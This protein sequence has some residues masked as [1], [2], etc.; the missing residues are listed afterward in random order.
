MTEAKELFYDEN[1][2]DKLDRD[3][4][5]LFFKNRLIDFKTNEIRIGK[6]EDYL[7]RCANINY[8]HI[9]EKQHGVIMKEI[10]EFM[11]KFL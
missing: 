1:F 2:L 10:N 11:R 8:I 4:Y 6:P 3:P 7:S 5:L 9:N